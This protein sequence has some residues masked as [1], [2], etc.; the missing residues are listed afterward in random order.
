MIRRFTQFLALAAT[1]VASGSVYQ[2]KAEDT[3]DGD[4]RDYYIMWGNPD[5]S[6]H[7][8]KWCGITEPCC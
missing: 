4:P 5:G 3:G 6:F 2:L 7:C 8:G 1:L